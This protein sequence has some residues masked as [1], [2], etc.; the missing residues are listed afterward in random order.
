MG[1]I[2]AVTGTLKK[3]RIRVVFRQDYYR[4]KGVT[5]FI[6]FFYSFGSVSSRLKLSHWH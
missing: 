3:K 4:K 2:S 6:T 1:V 5:S